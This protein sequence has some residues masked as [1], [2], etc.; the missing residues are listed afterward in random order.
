MWDV[1]AGCRRVPCVPGA[2]ARPGCEDTR[3]LSGAI[4][5]SWPL[6][7]LKRAPEIDDLMSTPWG[8]VL[9]A[10]CS[11]Y[12][13][14]PAALRSSARRQPTYAAAAMMANCA[15]SART[16][17]TRMTRLVT[18]SKCGEKIGWPPRC[19]SRVRKGPSRLHALVLRALRPASAREHRHEKEEG[20]HARRHYRRGSWHVKPA[21]AGVRRTAR[22]AGRALRAG[23]YGSV[24]AR[25]SSVPGP[26]AQAS[27]RERRRRTFATILYAASRSGPGISRSAFIRRHGPPSAAAARITAPDRT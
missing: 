17:E 7:A 25:S 15:A 14:A 21:S 9:H 5:L 18:K 26:I 12:R 23:I 11:S 1:R 24:R 2:A 27:P 8:V 20:R 6:E 13:R 19:I 4:N 3:R 22:R 10:R 16:M